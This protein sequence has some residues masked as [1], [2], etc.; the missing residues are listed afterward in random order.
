MKIIRLLALL[1]IL[2]AVAANAASHQSWVLGD[3]RCDSTHDPGLAL[4]TGGV[5]T[6]CDAWC[7]ASDQCAYYNFTNAYGTCSV[8]NWCTCRGTP[9]P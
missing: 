8:P 5:D 2:V 1:T 7:K 4:C 6:G 3:S 9:Q